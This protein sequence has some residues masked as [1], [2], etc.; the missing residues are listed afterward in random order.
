MFSQ[1]KFHAYAV[2]LTITKTDFMILYMELTMRICCQ[3]GRAREA[4]ALPADH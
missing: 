3:R 4:E 1:M 2:D